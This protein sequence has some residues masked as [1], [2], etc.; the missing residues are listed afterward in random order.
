MAK[1]VILTKRFIPEAVDRLARS[2]DLV[3]AADSGK[4][5]AEV[6]TENKDAEALISFLSDP[7]DKDTI[8]LGGNLKIIANYAVGYNNIDFRYAME[9]GL[10]VTHTPD[11][12]TDATADLAM[13]LILAVSRKIVAADRFL[14]S[15]Q[16]KGWDANL[17]LGKELNGSVIGIIGLGRIGLAVARRAPGFGLKAIYYS[18]PRENK[19]EQ[20]YGFEFVE[21]EELVTRADIITVHIPYS[22]D[23]HHLFNRQ[24]FDK[25]KPDAI[26]INTSRGPLMNEEHL[27]ER[28]EKYESFGAGLDVYEF[29]PQV[30]ERLKKLKNAVLVPHIG[31]AT[32]KARLGMAS[33]AIESVEQALS[34][35]TPAHLIPEFKK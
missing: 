7:I 30:N 9:K 16:F 13:A 5:P 25:M 28:L 24:V 4:S 6:L 34:G 10:F 27:A 2:F 21:F 32:Y 22:K 15:G 19:L 14:R 17:L 20:E 33:M 1:K 23:I 18:K 8:D 29:E 31:S 26:F 12:L 35:R 11:V 3:I